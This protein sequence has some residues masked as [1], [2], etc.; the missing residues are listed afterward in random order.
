MAEIRLTLIVALP[1]SLTSLRIISSESVCS[2]FF[3]SRDKYRKSG[4]LRQR[5]SS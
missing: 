1:P 5:N 4:P 3:Y 2:T